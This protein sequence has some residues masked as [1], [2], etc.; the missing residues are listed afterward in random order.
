[1]MLIIHGTIRFIRKININGFLKIQV[2]FWRALIQNK[3]ENGLGTS[4]IKTGKELPDIT[5]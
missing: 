4:Y 2:I 5:R 3:I 1:M